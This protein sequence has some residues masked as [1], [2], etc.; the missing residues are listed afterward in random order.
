V[1]RA[2]KHYAS[3]SFW[4]CYSKL[5]QDIR[6]IADKNFKLLKDSPSHSSLRLKKVGNYWSVRI[7]KKYRAIGIKSESRIVW[8]WIGKHSD[9]ERIVGKQDKSRHIF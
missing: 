9:Y 8:F 2:I 3:P 6:K 7:G 4:D 1:Q 5:P